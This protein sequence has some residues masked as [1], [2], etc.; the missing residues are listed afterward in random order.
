ME[1]LDEYT[2][3]KSARSTMSE[4]AKQEI[5][6]K[7]MSIWNAC[8]A[9]PY[10][11]KLDSMMPVEKVCPEGEV[12]GLNTAW[13]C[14]YS[15]Q[16]TT[17]SSACD[18]LMKR[19]MFGA[20]LVGDPT[21]GGCGF[22]PEK[23]SWQ[24]FNINATRDEALWSFQS[25]L[26]TWFDE[27]YMPLVGAVLAFAIVQFIAILFALCVRTGTDPGEIEKD[28]EYSRRSLELE[29][30]PK[31]PPPANAV[32]DVSGENAAGQD[33]L[34]LEDGASVNAVTLQ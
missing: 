20:F 29:M 25:A 15:K 19:K 2:R 1:F 30:G 18:F 24:Y 34:Q 27:H 6:D 7:Q 4:K 22:Y 3:E 33:Q 5:N 26:Y 28:R 16:Q 21:V 14:F 23:P 13:P 8:C 17:S 32:V 31:I 12:E 10:K 9:T 11:G